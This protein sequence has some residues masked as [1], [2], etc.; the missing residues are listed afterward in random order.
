M[1]ASNI[2]TQ[3]A[4]P[5]IGAPSPHSPVDVGGSADSCN[6]PLRLVFSVHI[7]GSVV[8]THLVKVSQQVDHGGAVAP[9]TW[10]TQSARSDM[11]SS[12]PVDTA[13][14]IRGA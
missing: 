11:V 4:D 5:S 12:L 8:K 7:L 1:S 9:Q 3:R 14:F 6:A 2:I 10:Q 13:W